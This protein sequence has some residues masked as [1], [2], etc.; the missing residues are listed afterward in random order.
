MAVSHM[1]RSPRSTKAPHG[2]MFSTRPGVAVLTTGMPRLIASEAVD[3]QD[4][5]PDGMIR[6]RV[7]RHTRSSMR[8][9]GTWSITIT[10]SGI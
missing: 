1:R 3:P 5:W 2:P 6:S 8:S 7:K 4:S 9:G 10:L